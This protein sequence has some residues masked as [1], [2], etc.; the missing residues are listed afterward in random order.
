MSGAGPYQSEIT[1]SPLGHTWLFDIDGTLF[2]HNPSLSGDHDDN[3][4]DDI[5]LPGVAQ[6]WES[7][8]DHDFVILLSARHPRYRLMT[9]NALRANGLRYNEIIFGL[10]KGERILINDAKPLGLLTAHAVNLV[11]DSGLSGL[12]FYIDPKL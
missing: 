1:L 3:G 10:P 12:T 5:L 11:R 8:P 6:F 7:L 9:E 2:A 4:P